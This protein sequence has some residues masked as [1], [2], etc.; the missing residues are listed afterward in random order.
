MVPL[1]CPLIL[2]FSPPG[3][4]E[5]Y[6]MRSLCRNASISPTTPQ[7]ILPQMSN[8]ASPPAELGVYLRLIRR[9]AA[10]THLSK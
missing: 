1:D 9:R 10:I 3:E 5:L 2:A 6:S 4:K 8:F 7:I